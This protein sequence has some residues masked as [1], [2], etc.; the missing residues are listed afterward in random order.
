VVGAR[1]LQPPGADQRGGRGWKFPGTG[2]QPV[3]GLD[4][5]RA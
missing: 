3:L 1:E 4:Q 5:D 2:L